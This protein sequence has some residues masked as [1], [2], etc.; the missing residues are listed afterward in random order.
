MVSTAR[1]HARSGA[2]SSPASSWCPPLAA[3][4]SSSLGPLT[5]A[6]ACSSTARS[7]SHVS[8]GGLDAMPCAAAEAHVPAPPPLSTQGVPAAARSSDRQGRHGGQKDDCRVQ[9]SARHQGG[10]GG[11]V[12]AWSCAARPCAAS[13]AGIS[14]ALLLTSTL[15]AGGGLQLPV[16]FWHQRG[17]E[18]PSWVCCAQKGEQGWGL[19]E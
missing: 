1:L 4:P 3:G 9:G 15:G 6:P 19:R 11:A 12:C 10:G 14:C 17:V 8:G 16:R 5:T 18:G 7:W 2:S 13:C